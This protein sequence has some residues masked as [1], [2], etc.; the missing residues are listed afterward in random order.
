MNI[1]HIKLYWSLK[2]MKTMQ[3]SVMAAC[4]S[5]SAPACWSKV[6]SGESESIHRGHLN[7]VMGKHSKIFICNIIEVWTI[8][9]STYPDPVC[10]YEIS[11]QHM[12]TSSSQDSPMSKTQRS[13][14]TGDRGQTSRPAPS[15]HIV[16]SPVTALLSPPSPL[17]PLTPEL[18]ARNYLTEIAN[19]KYLEILC[20]YSLDK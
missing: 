12:H 2:W 5:C 1:T 15:V 14:H 9:K 17:T 10:K 20:C 13:R 8:L 18:F 4:S 11:A 19:N 3:S 16:P 6:E 7:M